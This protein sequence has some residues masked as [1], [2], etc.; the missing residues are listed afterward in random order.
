MPERI[1][2]LKNAR[3]EVPAWAVNARTS[4]LGMSERS[5]DNPSLSANQN[6]AP[7]RGL[8]DLRKRQACLGEFQKIKKLGTP[9]RRG[10]G[11]L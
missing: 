9:F 3:N 11:L 6:R 10:F 7:V 2:K 8:F 1:P 4:P 5:E